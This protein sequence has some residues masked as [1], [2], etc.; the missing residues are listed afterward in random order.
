MECPN[1]PGKT[2]ISDDLLTFERLGYRKGPAPWQWDQNCKPLC[3]VAIVDGSIDDC[4]ADVHVEF[5]NA[6]VGGGV[7][8]GDAAQEETLFLV[9]PELM[10]SDVVRSVLDGVLKMGLLQCGWCRWRWLSRTGWS[11]KRRSR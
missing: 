11:T 4:L 6:F 8:T 3:K 1:V 5:A 2:G 10:V 9:K 7:M